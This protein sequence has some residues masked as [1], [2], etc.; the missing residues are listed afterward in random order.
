MDTFLDVVVSPSY[1]E[2]RA[3]VRWA[4]SPEIR[5]NDSDFYVFRSED[6]QTHWQLLNKAPVRGN[7]FV[8]TDFVVRDLLTTMHYRVLMVHHDSE[9]DSPVVGVFDKLTRREFGIVRRIM[10]LEML[11]MMQGRQGIEVQVRSPL[12]SGVTC[13]CVDP[14]TKQ[15]SQASLC[16]YCYGT[17]FEGGFTSP[18]TTWIRAE[19]WNVNTRADDPSGKARTDVQVVR[20]RA[21]TIPSLRTDDLVIHV[22]TDTRLAVAEVKQ[23]MFRGI[24]PVVS[25]P[26][27]VLLPRQDIRYKLP[28]T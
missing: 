8:D 13:R 15:S 16:P 9:T 3:V 18:V 6:G 21:L 12:T 11:C 25:L 26:G 1:G 4:V 14:V 19:D 22:P 5:H 23:E 10:Q 7:Q 27:F 28:V 20:G 17:R 2:D 24:V